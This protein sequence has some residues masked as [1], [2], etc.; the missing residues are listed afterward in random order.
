MNDYDLLNSIFNYDPETGIFTYKIKPC[1]WKN[2]GDIAGSING[3]G[4]WQLRYK[5]RYFRANRLAWL[6]YYGEW[7]KGVIDH[8]DTDILNNK[9]DNLRDIEAN[10]NQQNQR[11]PSKNNKTGYLG[12][13]Y[14]PDKNKYYSTIMLNRKS[15]HIGSFRTPEEAHE[16][17][18]RAKRELH[19]Y[20]TL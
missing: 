2:I 5:N 4:Y 19:E 8:K 3:K 12:V 1:S 16:A 18:I 17:Y 15:K 20:G 6:L 11:R 10:K 14:K 13:S 7:P 9:I